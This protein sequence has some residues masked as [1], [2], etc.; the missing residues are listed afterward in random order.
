MPEGVHDMRILGWKG[1][2]RPLKPWSWLKQNHPNFDTM[3][4]T[5]IPENRTLTGRTFPLSSYKGVSRR[6]NN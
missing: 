6:I 2:A 4:K 5:K 3:F 1:V